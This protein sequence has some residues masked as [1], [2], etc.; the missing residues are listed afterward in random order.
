MVDKDSPT[1]NYGRYRIDCQFQQKNRSKSTVLVKSY[2][3][4]SVDIDRRCALIPKKIGRQS[5]STVEM[6]M[7]SKNREY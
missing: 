4:K 1:R 7:D 3:K 6:V 5:I 2:Q